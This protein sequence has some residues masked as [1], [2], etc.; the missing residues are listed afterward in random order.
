MQSTDGD[1]A[2]GVWLDVADD[3]VDV[4]VTTPGSNAEPAADSAPASYTYVPP[5][6]CDA[7]KITKLRKAETGTEL[8]AAAAA[9][10]GGC[11]S[12]L[13]VWDASQ[14]C[15]ASLMTP[16]FG[17]D[18]PVWEGNSDGILIECLRPVVCSDAYV[19]DHGTSCANGTVYWSPTAPPGIP[20]P[21]ALAREA[22]S[23]MQLKA[24]QIGLEPSKGPGIVGLPSWYWAHD[25]ADNE[26]GTIETSASAGGITVTAR[27]TTEKIVWNLN[28]EKTL[29][30]DA[31]QPYKPAYGDQDSTCSY[32]YQTPG[33]KHITATSTWNI[34]WD[35]GPLGYEGTH[36]LTLDDTTE[37]DILIAEIQVLR[38]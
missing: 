18:D 27:A 9:L 28:D 13:G 4:G 20:D 29:E 22:V 35:S 8:E 6:T 5:A 36:D 1:S 38:Q 31:G 2:G 24:I 17:H 30:C 25:P 33:E 12:A 16:P 11:K 19:E 7:K 10:S 23:S 26:F 15:F 21:A 37:A 3:G 34:T 14:H 32:R